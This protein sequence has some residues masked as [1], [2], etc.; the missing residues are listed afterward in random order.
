MQS[1]ASAKPRG[2][3]L[4]CSPR[5]YVGQLVSIRRPADDR[6]YYLF[7]TAIYVTTGHLT[8]YGLKVITMK[9]QERAGAYRIQL[10]AVTKSYGGERPAVNNLNLTIEGGE[11]CVLLGTSGCGKTTTLKMI[12]RLIEPTAGRIFVGDKNVLD[13]DPITLRRSIG[14]VIQA[15]GLL[16]HMTVGENVALVPQLLGWPADKL[17][18]RGNELLDL[19]HLP[20]REFA[21]RLPSELSGGQRQRVGFARALAAEP[22]V[23][24]L[25]EPFGALD[26]ITRDTLQTEL[27]QLQR[28]LGFTAV[29]VTHDMTEALLLADRIVIMDAGEVIQ[30]GTPAQVM[31]EPASDFVRDLTATPRRQAAALERLIH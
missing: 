22:R 16:P 19:I 23:M 6:D 29:M 27:H 10:D 18:A 28:R 24:L 4:R 13:Q 11:F 21:H 9:L 1:L 20:H 7:P 26:P 8:G 17:E 2:R 15:V 5:R 3:Q 31:A 30:I 14:Y 12:N 25:D